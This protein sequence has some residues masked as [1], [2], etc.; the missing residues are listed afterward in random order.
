LLGLPFHVSLL[1]F[2][3]IPVKIVGQHGLN[4]RN[5]IFLSVCRSPACLSTNARRGA[6]STN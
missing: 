5:D 6:G 2:G 1:Q 3:R 4:E